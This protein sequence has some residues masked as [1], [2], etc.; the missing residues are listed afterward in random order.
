MLA[1]LRARSPSSRPLH[2][3]HALHLTLST[4]RTLRSPDGNNCICSD[5]KIAD[6][7]FYAGDVKALRQYG[8]GYCIL[9]MLGRAW[10]HTSA[11]Y[12]WFQGSTGR[13]LCL[14]SHTFAYSLCPAY[15]SHPFTRFAPALTSSA[16]PLRSLTHPIRSLA[17]L[18]PSPHTPSS[19]ALLTRS[20]DSWK[21][22]G[23]GA[24]TDMQLW[25]DLIKG[26]GGKAITVE[27]CHWGSKVPFKPNATW[28]PWN[29]YRTSGD[30]RASYSSVIGNLA[31]TVQYAKAN[32]SRPGCWAYPDMLEVGCQHGPGGKSDPGLNVAETRTHFGAWAIVSSP[33]TLS[34]DGAFC[35]GGEGGEGGGRGVD[36]GGVMWVGGASR[37]G[38]GGSGGFHRWLAVVV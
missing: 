4:S 2:F 17:S 38:G 21:L 13:L 3:A 19:Y 11:S 10:S 33:L 6:K 15:S 29:L 12:A 28:C 7:K 5:Q 18:P 22:D 34:H 27:N 30:V 8:Y 14:P 37:V 23:C 9:R 16:R 36:V 31:T 25:N 1:P 35:W 24:Q 32:L 26:D 20:F